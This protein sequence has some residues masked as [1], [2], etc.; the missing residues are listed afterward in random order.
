MQFFLLQLCRYKHFSNFVAFHLSFTMCWPKV[1]Y[2]LQTPHAYS[3]VFCL[4]MM[5]GNFKLQIS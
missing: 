1:M 3:S 4:P 2:R 5:L